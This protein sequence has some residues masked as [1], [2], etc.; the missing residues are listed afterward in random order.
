M[1]EEKRQKQKLVRRTI[2]RTSIVKKAHLIW[3]MRYKNK[4]MLK[5]RCYGCL[6]RRMH[7]KHTRYTPTRLLFVRIYC[8][9]E[10]NGSCRFDLHVYKNA[11]RFTS[12]SIWI[13]WQIRHE[14][15]KKLQNFI[16]LNSDFFSMLSSWACLSFPITKLDSPK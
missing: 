2:T 1:N 8:H 11:K 9:S 5:I 10:S 12:A 7:L 4:V 6:L 3:E 15:K 14:N 16:H 13:E